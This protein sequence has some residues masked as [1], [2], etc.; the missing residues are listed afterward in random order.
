MISIG[1][2]SLADPIDH[3]NFKGN[4]IRVDTK[5]KN[6]FNNFRA[7]QHHGATRKIMYGV[8]RY[9]DPINYRNTSMIG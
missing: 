5:A 7:N 6:N 3:V 9:I 1:F 2:I 4:Y 8:N